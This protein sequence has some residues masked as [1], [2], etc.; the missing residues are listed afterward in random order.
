MLEELAQRNQ[1]DT[2][3]RLANQ[4]NMVEFLRRQG[5]DSESI[6]ELKEL[7][8]GFGVQGNLQE[9]L[10]GPFARK[11]ILTHASVD[12]TRYSDGSFPVLYGALEAMTAYCE[13]KYI[14]V[15]QRSGIR[16]RKGKHT[17][18]I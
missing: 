2:V 6:K 16:P 7:L 11:H 3:H 10:D 5:F 8:E 14:T 4:R 1:S 13:I 18:C 17:I 15:V 9:T 12:C